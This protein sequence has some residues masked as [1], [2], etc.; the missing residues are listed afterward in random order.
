MVE[1]MTLG[2]VRSL[3]EDIEPYIQAVAQA[4]G[5]EPDEVT[6]EK[7]DSYG[8]RVFSVCGEE[9]AVGND[10][11]A[12]EAVRAYIKDLAW[13]FKPEFIASHTKAGASNGMIKAIAALQESCENSN[14]DILSLIEDID[15]FVEDAISSDGR[16]MFLSSYDS[17]EQEV[18]IGDEYYYAYRQN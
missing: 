4:I 15:A 18:K 13:S 14:D 12:N 5:C 2:Q 17:N 16:G 7:Y 8:L 6:E 3:I 10:N 1:S 11:E 9:W